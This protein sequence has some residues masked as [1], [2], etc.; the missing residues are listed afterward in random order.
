MWSE[1]SGTDEVRRIC[2]RR[3]G[4]PKTVTRRRRWRDRTC[5]QS[6]G[7]T[8]RRLRDRETDRQEKWGEPE[9]VGCD[10]EKGCIYSKNGTSLRLPCPT[11]RGVYMCSGWRSTSIPRLRDVAVGGPGWLRGLSVRPDPAVGKRKWKGKE[12]RG[13]EMFRRSIRDEKGEECGSV[14]VPLRETWDPSDVVK[15]DP[16]T[17]K[18]GVDP[19]NLT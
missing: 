12:W 10:L 16:E 15:W 14:W 13:P 17:F 2:G 7:W 6:V 1:G 9:T 3:E 5:L 19:V 18:E 8:R 4:R 11:R